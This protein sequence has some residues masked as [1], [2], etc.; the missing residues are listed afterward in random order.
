MTDPQGLP[1]GVYARVSTKRQAGEKQTSIPDQVSKGRAVCAALG[2]PVHDV[3]I[4]PGVS[5]EELEQ[6]P[7]MRRLLADVAAGRVRVAVAIDLNRIARDEFVF[8]QIFRTLDREEAF[9]HADGQLYD[10]ENLSQLLTRGIKAVVASH[11]RRALIKQLANGQR[12]RASA[13]GWPGGAPPY[14]Y[15]LVWPTTAPGVKPKAQVEID[16]AEVEMLL[17]AITLLVDERTEDGERLTTGLVADRLNAMGYTTRGGAV[18]PENRTPGPWSHSNLRRVLSSRSLLGEVYWGKPDS[19]PSGK[20]RT[21]VRRD[22]TPYYG[23]T[24]KMQLEPLITPERFDEIQLAL[25]LRAYGYKAESKPYPL[26]GATSACGGSLGGVYRKDR[27][28]RQYRCNRRKSN[29]TQKRLCDCPRINAD[30]LDGRVW[31]EVSGL[32]TDPARLVAMAADYLGVEGD[33]ARRGA[34][35]LPAIERKIAQLQRA[36]V[37]RAADAL[38]SGISPDLLR[39][40]VGQIEEELAGLEEERDRLQAARRDRQS[41]QD[42]AVALARLAEQ[43]A[44]RLPQIRMEDRRDVLRLLGVNVTVLEQSSQPALR[45]TGRLPA[46]LPAQKAVTPATWDRGLRS[47]QRPQ[48]R[49]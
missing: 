33:R 21:R 13:G 49:S 28:L 42:R 35:R 19:R 47:P 48:H 24:I 23:E 41:G 18:R 37:S 5:G 46:S 34:D 17:T 22:G 1:A 43:A 11:D 45:I 8:Q 10:P 15:R 30:W 9:V 26:S 27:D 38:K 40:A 39:A 16:D 2:L 3:Y 20:H 36:R 44:T 29:A 4:D 12:A 14:G 25:S 32:L 7:E 31:D 6:R